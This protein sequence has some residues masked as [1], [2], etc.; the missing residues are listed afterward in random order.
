M[1]ILKVLIILF[2]ALTSIMHILFQI[3]LLSFVNIG[4]YTKFLLTENIL[5]A[6]VF[7]LMCTALIYSKFSITNIC[8]DTAMWLFFTICVAI[9]RP[10][11]TTLDMINLTFPFKQWII[12]L[13]IALTATVTNIFYLQLYKTRKTNTKS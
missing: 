2:N 4:A 3:Y 6:L 9:L 1:K 7:F 8:Y 12:L 10:E 5:I 11:H 13:G